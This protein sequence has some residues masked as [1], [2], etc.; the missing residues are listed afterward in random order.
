MVMAGKIV[1]FIFFVGL[2]TIVV[3]TLAPL[4]WMTMIAFKKFNEGDDNK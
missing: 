2:T 3:I 4:V 1:E